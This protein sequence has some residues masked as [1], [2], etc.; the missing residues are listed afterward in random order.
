MHPG[1][2]N[3]RQK[4]VMLWRVQTKGWDGR[5]AR[6]FTSSWEFMEKA[7]CRRERLWWIL[8]EKI[9]LG[10]MKGTAWAKSWNVKAPECLWKMEHSSSKGRCVRGGMN[11]VF[12]PEHGLGFVHMRKKWFPG[13]P[14]HSESPWGSSWDSSAQAHPRD[15]S[16]H[17]HFQWAP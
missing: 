2:C 10:A 12:I 17:V 9:G 1:H 13:F 5:E 6:R 16:V 11:Q 15:L 8:E 7:S 3:R 14:V 4:V